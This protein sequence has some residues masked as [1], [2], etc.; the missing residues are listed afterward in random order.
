MEPEVIDGASEI[1]TS[2]QTE[3][4]KLV[5]EDGVM[6]AQATRDMEVND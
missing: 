3:A 2:V 5:I 6:I 1:Y 4:A